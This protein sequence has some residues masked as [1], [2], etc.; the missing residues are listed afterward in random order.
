MA[1]TRI[2]FIPTILT[3]V[4]QHFQG[5]R[6]HAQPLDLMYAAAASRHTA[7]VSIDFPDNERFSA[8]IKNADVLVFST[9][10]S[11]LQWNNHP[12][13]LS[14][15]ENIWRRSL[16][17][18][19]ENK[20]I[21]IIIGPHSSY[22]H[23]YLKNLG[24]DFVLSG[25]PELYIPKLILEIRSSSTSQIEVLR[26]TSEERKI[27]VSTELNDLPLPAYDLLSNGKFPAHNHFQP[28]TLG[29]LYE[30]SR[31]CPF[32]CS[33]CNTV[34]HRRKY[35]TKSP[36][37]IQSDLTALASLSNDKYVYFI[38]ESF[39]VQDDWT[40]K[41]TELISEL[42][43]SFGAQSNLRYMH[44]SKLERLA[45][46]GFVHIEF[47]LESGNEGILEAVG[48]N[49]R[50]RE[51]KSKVKFAAELGLNP[52][53]FVQVGLPGETK[54]TASETVS[55]LEEL[56]H[57]T[58]ISIAHPTPYPNTALYRQ[59]VK[60]GLLS[61]NYTPS[62]WK[63]SYRVAGRIGT[64]FKFNHERAVSYLSKYGPNFYVGSNS[65]IS[66][67]ADTIDLIDSQDD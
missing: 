28:G 41:L 38:D 50:L 4:P 13:D 24:A 20:P 27:H 60:E 9:T 61:E 22:A 16:S 40:H 15:F 66:L 44:E 19:S 32:F 35:R 23:D 31:G 6:D 63:N 47:G 59:G 14:I 53:L 11:Y 67:K 8:S 55:L 29:H 58:R 33:F 62:N 18:V 52:L 39:G 21:T 56:D 10:N 37:K 43:L 48:K 54:E 45:K 26:A 34:H 17:I 36:E 1:N 25:E 65:M 5:S 46:A 49:N 7:D 2:S 64:S 3:D 30:A 12:L 42:P 51:L 57:R